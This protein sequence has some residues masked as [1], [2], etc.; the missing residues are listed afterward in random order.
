MRNSV[1]AIAL[2]VCAFVVIGC[3]SKVEANPPQAV[4][5]EKI[6]GTDLK[7]ITLAPLAAQRLAVETAEVTRQGTGSTSRLIVP[8]AALYYDAKGKVWVYTNPEG[9][10]FVRAEVT[11]DHI[12]GDKA[13]LS[14]GP[15]AGTK[16]ATVGV[17]EL[18]GVEA[19]VG[20][21]H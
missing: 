3:G 13:F 20:G 15:G 14:D 4:T 9:L 5:V 6:E 10:V 11:V 12:A 19:G 18:H 2:L 17:A 8:Y 7:K 16:V 1:L 21:G